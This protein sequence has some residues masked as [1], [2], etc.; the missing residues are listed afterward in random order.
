[1]MPKTLGKE[2][3]IKM[4][5]I[6]GFVRI[7]KETF[8][9]YSEAEEKLREQAKNVFNF[10]SRRTAVELMN[11]L[12]SEIC[13]FVNTGIHHSSRYS[14]VRYV[15]SSDTTR[16]TFSAYSGERKVI[17]YLDRQTGKRIVIKAK[18]AELIRGL[19]SEVEEGLN[20]D[21]LMPLQIISGSNKTIV[22]YN[23][24]GNCEPEHFAI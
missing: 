17:S 22:Y 6:N 20:K 15:L 10:P 14:I 7:K 18:P 1:M 4:K 2:Q 23:P 11:P 5:K 21:L 9:L 19:D 13:Y 24:Q 3:E 12:I 16:V 8:E